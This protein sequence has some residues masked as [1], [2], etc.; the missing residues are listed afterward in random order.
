VNKEDRDAIEK[1]ADHTHLPYNRHEIF[2]RLSV[3][4]KNKAKMKRAIKQRICEL[5]GAY[6]S[7]ATFIDDDEVDYMQDNLGTEKSKEIGRRVI[8]EIDDLTTEMKEFNLL[9]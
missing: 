5:A 7:L 9:G 2:N 6:I 3:L 8:R 4:P 1:I